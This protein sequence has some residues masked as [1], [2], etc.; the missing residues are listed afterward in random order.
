MD[1]EKLKQVSGLLK[2]ASDMLLSVESSSNTSASAPSR[3]TNTGSIAETLTRARSMMQSSTSGGLYR[4]LNRNERLR[5]VGTTTK[6]KSEKKSKSPESKPFEF[7]L[8]RGNSEE[9]DEEDEIET[10]KKDKIVERGIVVLRENDDESSVRGKITS[11]LKARYNILGPNDFE[12]VKVTQKRVS[13]LRLGEDT[14]YNYSVVKKLAG[15]GLLYI[16]IKRGFDFVLNESG[17]NFSDSG[18]QDVPPQSDRDEVKR[19]LDW[20][21]GTSGDY[22]PAQTDRNQVQEQL[23]QS[24][25]TSG[26]LSEQ[27]LNIDA[28]NA[29]PLSTQAFSEQKMGDIDNFFQTVVSEFP[30]T[31]SEPTEM[32]RYLQ[33]KIVT[34][35]SLE[36]TDL[37]A[38]LEGESN[39]ITVDR[40]DILTTTFEELKEVT[41][42]RLTFDVQF[43][44]EE[45]VDSGGPRKE[46]IRLCNQKIKLKYFDNGLKEHLSEDYFYVGQM[47]SI[48][49]LQN[50]QLPTYIPEKILHAI[51]VD[52]GQHVSPCV[53]ELRRG[54][55]TLGIHM[56]GRKFPMFLYLLR[57][58]TSTKLSVRKLLF[59]LKA[60][61]S[62]EGSNDVSHEKAVYNQFVK[63]VREAYSGRRV[64]TPE[65]ILEFVTGASDEPPLGFGV[66]PH[67][68]FV[69][70]AVCELKSSENEVP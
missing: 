7:A 35:R 54:M 46:W 9:S 49:L 51:F 70:A 4:R 61:F 34:G 47:A 15:Q 13:V 6:N 57:P 60:D 53:L 33:K 2:E 17:E 67:I 16:R 21:A 52:E 1:E 14:E 41:N 24:A 40:D 43:Y 22:F 45:A 18:R 32:L 29:P 62:E 10:L 58:P 66:K 65:N 20:S 30:S 36:I 64:V 26:E 8:L 11:S 3:Q 37:T 59:L 63:Y 38:S 23:D 31:I 5:A 56:F 28:G 27:Q 55:D 50:G 25:D 19:P 69:E 39:F 12:F 68:E 42:P 48:A 44:R